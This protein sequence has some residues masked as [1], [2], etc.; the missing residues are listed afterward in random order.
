MFG[1]QAR[2]RQNAAASPRAPA[3]PSSPSITAAVG[4][5]DT[6]APFASVKAA[7]NLFVEA[8]PKTERPVIKKCKVIEE[9]V[10][11][12]EAQLHW[13]LK[14]I[15][16]LKEYVKT[17]EA[18]K[19]KALGELDKA[20]KTL[21]ELTKKLE[22]ASE[23]KHASIQAT[24][25]ANTRAQELEE[26]KSTKS[27]AG[28]EAWKETVNNE[29]NQYKAAAN[30]LIAAKQEFNN[31]RQ[32]FDVALE[33]KLAA[34]QRAAEAQNATQINRKKINQ[35]SK[36]VVEL[37]VTLERV[38]SA[39]AKAE[40]EHVK[41]MAEK[42][43]VVDTTK[44]AKEETDLK[45]QSLRKEAEEPGNIEKRLEETTGAISV[46]EEQLKE[47]RAADKELL[48]SANSELDDAEKRLE[49]MKGEETSLRDFVESLK[50]EVENVK[51][52]ISVSREEELK[53]EKL[54]GEVDQIKIHVQDAATE[55]T[56]ATNDVDELQLKIREMLLEAEK[57][58]EEEAEMKRQVENL[59]R[60]AQWSEVEIKEA[61]SKLE[62]AEREVEEAKAAQDLANDQI[63]KRSSMKEAIDS[64]SDNMIVLS[65][66]DFEALSKKSEE[67]IID[68]DTKVGTIMAEVETIKDKERGILE[69]LEKSMKEQKEIE[70][71]I[72]KAQ[73]T[74]EAADEARQTVE[75]ELNKWRE[76][77][78]G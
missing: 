74:A 68:A 25:A 62:I 10:L 65:I 24:E 46:L 23:S 45:I 44:N 75:S 63:R 41:F 11:G 70:E 66:E 37:S 38:K 14:E 32:D 58:R 67:A 21:Q 6:A 61:E 1:F 47:V 12:Q 72:T 39:S 59:W 35:L 30:Q 77:T 36:D 54:Q 27:K 26:L 55:K 50:Q 43:T 71:E 69:D 19:E 40:E 64:N 49:E 18:T 22:A 5:I 28:D 29:R 9:S 20:N 57:A 78:K 73:K 60:D 4:E 51:R 33:A 31:L 2:N 13:I 15:D 17:A 42:E 16:R 34:I 48:N 8:S 52:D 76:E 7:V 56:K 3:D 53:R